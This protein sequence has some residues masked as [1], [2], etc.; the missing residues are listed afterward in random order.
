MSVSS[1]SSTNS[2]HGHTA[3]RY[4]DI[5]LIP[6][7]YVKSLYGKA[8]LLPTPTLL[9]MKGTITLQLDA[10]DR[11]CDIISDFVQVNTA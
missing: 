7:S 9:V 11:I 10:E 6:E 4:E 1:L 5:P 8:R 3:T 2:T